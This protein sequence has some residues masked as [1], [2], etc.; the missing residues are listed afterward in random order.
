MDA[1]LLIGTSTLASG[2][3]FSVL[4]IRSA[5]LGYIVILLVLIL[6]VLTLDLVRRLFTRN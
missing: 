3:D 5:D 1:G 2:T 6:G 4:E